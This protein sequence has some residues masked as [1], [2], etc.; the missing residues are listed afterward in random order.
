MLGA[1]PIPSSIR[2]MG[3]YRKGIEKLI[4]MKHVIAIYPEAHIWPFYTDIRPFGTESFHYPIDLNVP[5]FSFTNI[6]IKRTLGII[7]MPKVRTYIDGPFYPDIN[8]DKKERIIKLRDE[9]YSAM[10]KRVNEN[11]KYEYAKYIYVD[12]AAKVGRK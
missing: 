9:I 1:V 8:L 4:E 5:C 11:P 2:G 3:K 10:K 7:K 6:Y 12:D